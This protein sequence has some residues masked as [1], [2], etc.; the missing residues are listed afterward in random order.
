MTRFEDKTRHPFKCHHGSQVVCHEP[1]CSAKHS[2]IVYLMVLRIRE[3][4]S[5]C[6]VNIVLEAL[7]T[8]RRKFHDHWA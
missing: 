8:T 3:P 7:K 4:D 1:K 5:K 2:P 6:L